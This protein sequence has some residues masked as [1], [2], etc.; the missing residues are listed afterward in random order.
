MI[1]IA[2]TPVDAELVLP[3]NYVEQ[4]VANDDL[5]TVQNYYE[6]QGKQ[7]GKKGDASQL[8]GVNL[9]GI[10]LN[11]G[12]EEPL[13]FTVGENKTS[14]IVINVSGSGLSVGTAGTTYFNAVLERNYIDGNGVEQKEYFVVE[15]AV[16]MES[17]L[18]VGVSYSG[19]ISAE[20]LPQGTY[21]VSLQEASTTENSFLDTLINIIGEVA[22]L[23]LLG[24]ATFTITEQ[25]DKYLGSNEVNG[26]VIN[27]AAGSDDVSDVVNST[28][29]VTS[30][31]NEL[32]Q[33][34][35]AINDVNTVVQG[36]YGTL[37]ISPN[38]TYK[39]VSNGN[40]GD[41]GKVDTFTYA[42]RD[43][44]GSEDTAQLN[45]RV[46]GEN[47]G[48]VWNGTAD[49]DAVLPEL[50]ANTNTTVV[51]EVTNKT[52]VVT[53]S[54][55]TFNVSGTLGGG[56]GTFGGSTFT[57]ENTDSADVVLTVS[58][59]ALSISLLPT[60]TLTI[61]NESGQPVG[62]GSGTPLTGALGSSR[63]L[64]IENLGPG[65]YTIEAS[66]SGNTGL[67][68]TATLSLVQTLTHY[69]QIESLTTPDEVT[70]NLITD[71]TYLPSYS[72]FKVLTSEGYQ[73]VGYN[74]VTIQGEYG[75]LLVEKDGSYT[76]TPNAGVVGRQDTF[77]YSLEMFGQ[78]P[79]FSTLT[80]TIP[81]ITQGD[82]E[83][84]TLVSGEGNDSFIGGLGGDVLI[85]NLLEAADS[86]G[87]NG[88]DV[89]SDF[90]QA[91]GDMIDL[92]ALLA[93]QTVTNA[94]L[95]NFV[96]VEQDGANT[97]VSIDRD[98]SQGNTYAKVDLIVLENTSPSSL[99][100]DE[101]IKYNS[102]L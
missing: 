84:N 52:E 57:V 43:L 15:N 80:V 59:P 14:D 40:V 54:P 7:I 71:D 36:A 47:S 85:Y 8:L 95:G 42:I 18:L 100:L 73:E 94:T 50:V 28:T 1:N 89:W 90:N 67:G 21:T 58:I 26:N 9:A 64:V 20:G 5:A 96:S 60:F 76:Y 97:V 49:Q 98:G 88:T 81:A 82:D 31:S 3:P 27:S 33:P 48:I 53:T 22:A 38:G 19:T 55:G 70:G 4:V 69:N 32:G 102:P 37:Y 63:S 72:T 91:E 41:I 87:G 16:Q 30:V 46:D 101:L 66:A 6:E 45:I 24:N 56:R 51:P 34:A 83:R 78:A 92:T 25:T 77:E 29:Y 79:Q 17:V 11:I 93:G 39:Y 75:T 10:G 35:V 12:S 61:K 2:G 86:A 74:G 13:V 44:N 23:D 68:F 65:T 62:T 99:V